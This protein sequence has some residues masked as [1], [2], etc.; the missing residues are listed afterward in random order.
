MHTDT[1][2]SSIVFPVISKGWHYRITTFCCIIEL[3]QS[4]ILYN[5]NSSSNYILTPIYHIH[6]K[7]FAI[8]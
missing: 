6:H 7:I 8:S 4:R 5:N 3:Q 1:F 2:T